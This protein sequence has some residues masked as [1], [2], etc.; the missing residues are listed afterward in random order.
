MSGVVVATTS[1]SVEDTS[2]T[3]ESFSEDESEIGDDGRVVPPTAGD[4]LQKQNRG[5]ST[6]RQLRDTEARARTLP[7]GT[8]SNHSVDRTTAPKNPR[9]SPEQ[10]RTMS[11]G[12]EPTVGTSKTFPTLNHSESAFTYRNFTLRAVTENSSV[13]VAKNLSFP[14]NDSRATP[15]VTDDQVEY[16]SQ[17]F[18]STIYPSDKRLFGA[19]TPRFGTNSSLAADGLVSESYYQSPD[20]ESRTVILI[21]NIRDENYYNESYPVFTA[22]FYSPVIQNETDRN[23]VTIDAAEWNERLGPMNASWRPSANETNESDKED[24][25]AVE[26][27]LTHELQHLI[28]NDHDSD[29]TT[30]INEGLSDYAEYAAGYGLPSDHIRAFEH[31]PNNSLVEWEDQGDQHVL[32]DYGGAALFHV[33]LAQQYGDDA[34]KR[35]IREQD[36]GIEGVES[37]LDDTDRPLSF[38]QLYQDFATALVVDSAN[39]THSSDRYGFDGVSVNVSTSNITNSTETAAWGLQATTLEDLDESLLRIT[40]NGSRYQPVAWE[41]TTPPTAPNGSNES[42]LWSGSGHLRDEMAIMRVDLHDTRNPALSF[43]TLYDIEQG[44]DA[45]VV[46]VSTDGGASWESLSNQNTTDRLAVPESA[47]PAVKRH[48]PGFT[49]DTNGRW[50]S[51]SFDL[52]RY[53]NQSVLVS[54]RYLTDW[55]TAGND[56]DQPGTGWYLRNVRVPG[57]GV[58]YADNS[59]DPFVDPSAIRDQPSRYQFTAIAINDSGPVT[60]EQFGTTTFTRGEPRELNALFDQPPY[61]RVVVLGTWAARTNETGT[62]PY[63]VELTPFSDVIDPADGDTIVTNGSERRKYAG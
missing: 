60:V 27:T 6:D 52:S 41:T 14:T 35:L 32:A 59:T 22:G 7:H 44:W 25:F 3:T 19:P 24:A 38:Y 61:D 48:Q 33:Y 15:S 11:A 54:F 18:E 56:S 2:F 21:D 23:V 40:A 51:E 4:R 17:A 45:G 28:H 55:A 62:V 39:T 9:V 16:L 5:I 58:T 8:L 26:G 63:S 47:H 29:E 20:N 1:V 34:I 12:G 13:W 36:N 42:V 53:Q 31:R 37:V 57:T 43:E 30:W 10:Y 46:Q 50:V 49:G